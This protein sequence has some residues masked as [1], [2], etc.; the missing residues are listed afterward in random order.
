MQPSGERSWNEGHRE[1]PE[2]KGREEN[3]VKINMS[4]CVCV[5][6]VDTSVMGRWKESI[7]EREALVE[8]ATVNEGKELGTDGQSH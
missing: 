4:I 7:A 8:A 5:I 1:P 2:G 3:I 6:S